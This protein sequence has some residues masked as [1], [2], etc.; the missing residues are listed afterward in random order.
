MTSQV[1]RTRNRRGEG[2]RLRDEIVEAASALLEETG[3]EDAVTLRGVARRLGIAAPSIYPHFDDVDAI[4]AAV[5]AE[6]FAELDAA[7][8]AVPVSAGAEVSLRSLCEAYV[9]FARARPQRY[10]V[11]FGRH[12]VDADA[13]MS[14]PRSVEELLGGSAFGRLLDAVNRQSSGP[15]GRAIVDATALWVSLHGYVSLRAAVPAFPWPEG[16]GLVDH[17]VARLAPPQ[18]DAP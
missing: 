15:E 10:R 3:S 11:M 7:L 16:D 18:G 6:A 9:G 13:A 14:A 17:L 12:R 1:R 2:A 8:D 4:L 5:V